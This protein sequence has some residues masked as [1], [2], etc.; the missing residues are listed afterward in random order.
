MRRTTAIILLSFSI[1]CATIDRGPVQ[2]VR[3][4]SDPPGAVVEL[5]GC[6]VAAEERTTPVTVM[7]PRRVKR[8][9][10]LLLHEGYEPARVILARRRAP[11]PESRHA[12]FDDLCGDCNSLE[13]VFV[14]ATVGGLLYGIG[15]GVDAAAGAN[16][17]LDPREVQIA[18]VPVR[19]R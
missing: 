2:R 15:R 4:A 3:I 5:T 9:S 7:I 13:D 11:E 19:A 10:V 12:V 16:Y 1:S 18:M 14:A 6:G 17:E 8:C